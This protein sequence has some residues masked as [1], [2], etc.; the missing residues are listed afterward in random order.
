M[1]ADQVGG[2]VVRVGA[3]PPVDRLM[4]AAEAAE[5]L[6]ISTR[7]LDN[8]HAR[9]VLDKVHI[10]GAVR[11]RESDVARLIREGAATPGREAA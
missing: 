3:V 9:G 5:R 2:V 11:Y 1:A 8:L 6:A 4:K 10:F 7:Q